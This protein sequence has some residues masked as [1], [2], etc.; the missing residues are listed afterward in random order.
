[1]PKGALPYGVYPFGLHTIQSLPWNTLVTNKQLFLIS[2]H[3]RSVAAL[4]NG[5]AFPCRKC[6][7]LSKH[8]ALLGI[9]DRIANGCHDSLKHAYR[10]H[11]QL[12]D[13]VHCRQNQVDT[14]R[15]GGLN[16]GRKLTVKCRTMGLAN[17]I[18]ME[19]VRG[20]IPSV[21]R[22][23]RVTLRN[24]TG[25]MGVLEKFGAAVE[26]LSTTTDPIEADLHRMYLFAKLG[27]A[28]V[29]RIAQHSLN[30]PSAR[31]ATRRL[32]VHPLRASPSYPTPD[33]IHHNLS[34]VFPPKVED[35]NPHPF[36]EA[37]TMFTDELKLEERLRWDAATNNILGVCREHSKSVSLEFRS[38]LQADALHEALRNTSLP[39]HDHVHLAMEATVIAVRV[40][41]DNACQNAARPIIVSGTC[42]RENVQAQHSL[43]L[44]AINT[45]DAHECRQRCR[46]YSIAT[47]GDSRRHRAVA[48]L[49]LQHS[50]TS[51]SLIYQHLHPLPL[52]N[53][54]CG[55]DDL[56][57][58]LDY[59][60]VN[61]RF[62][63][64]LLR[65]R[66]ITIDG[67]SITRAI[68]AQHLLWEGQEHHHIH[69][70]LSPNDKQ[71]VTLAYTLLL[72]I[73]DFDYD[74]ESSQGSP[75]F[76]EARCVL[77]L[78]GHMYR[79]ILEAY[80]CG[81]GPLLCMAWYES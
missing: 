65:G 39:E 50:L 68:L 14:L 49:T 29:A 27:G 31:T 40:L 22:K 78:L 15:F 43:L 33:D 26:R 46:L 53:L 19:I 4:E 6:R 52:F 12:V 18:L 45:F 36:E 74:P 34:I 55:E 56:T 11:F 80:T 64:T 32:D 41:S 76:L 60:H 47:D 75:A 28:Q 54:L 57:G 1:M 67:I 13:V 38:M 35:V 66:G 81:S 37:V 79:Y 59:K 16:M 70:L 61:K 3:C 58:D 8:D 7:E 42:K 48:L 51:A 30:L 62:R 17:R 9:R 23:L 44:N 72:S 24:G 73:S 2:T 5:H 21:S 10:S 71:D 77:A 63:N 69:S 20:D 25:L